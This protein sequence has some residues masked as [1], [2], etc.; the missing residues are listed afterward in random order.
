MHRHGLT[1]DTSVGREAH[2]QARAPGSHGDGPGHVGHRRRGLVNRRIPVVGRHGRPFTSVRCPLA[3][4]RIVRQGH[5]RPKRD[6]RTGDPNRAAVIQCSSCA[7]PPSRRVRACICASP[8]ATEHCR[9]ASESS[10]S[11]RAASLSF[12]LRRPVQIRASLCAPVVMEARRRARRSA[13]PLDKNP[14]AVAR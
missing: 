5:A 7:R 4:V 1:R 8:V 6:P 11:A 12:F 3:R 2:L 13:A 14:A 10:W 9:C